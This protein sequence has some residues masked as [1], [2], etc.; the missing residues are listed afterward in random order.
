MDLIGSTNPHWIRCIKPHPVKKPRMFHGRETMNQLESSV[1]LGTVKIRKAGYPVRLPRDIFCHR[2]RLC[3]SLQEGNEKELVEDIIKRAQLEVAAQVQLGSTK[4][5]LKSEAH[6][7][8]EKLRSQYLLQTS[9]SLQ[10]ICRGY[11]ARHKLF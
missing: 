10:R 5:F 11:L 9:M 1:V 8:L 3:S 2:Y 7:I 6:D 4:V